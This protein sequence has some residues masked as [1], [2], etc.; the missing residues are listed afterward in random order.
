MFVCQIDET[1]LGEEPMFKPQKR[2]IKYSPAPKHLIEA[3]R[4]ELRRLVELP[5]LDANLGMIGRFAN[6]AD[7]MLMCVKSPEAVMRDEHQVTVPGVVGTASNV[8]TYGASILKQILPA[9]ASYQK[10]Q[11]ESPEALTYAIATARRAGMTDLAA[12]L[13]KKLCGKSLDGDRPIL[14]AATTMPSIESYLLADASKAGKKTNG[15]AKET[16]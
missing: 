12:E 8:E 9:L 14:G 3:V 6:Q 11:Q 1:Q 2:D 13:E 16:T 15:K 10:A 7:D 5:D 4:K